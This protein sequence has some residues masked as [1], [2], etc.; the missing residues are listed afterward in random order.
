MMWPK[1]TNGFSVIEIFIVF[2][3]L[4]VIF[5]LVVDEFAPK[6]K[7]PLPAKVNPVAFGPEIAAP[8]NSSD[9]NGQYHSVALFEKIRNLHGGELLEHHTGNMSLVLSCSI[10]GDCLI[11]DGFNDD[12]G[13]D[14]QSIYGNR[15]WWMNNFF[16]VIRPDDPDY[17]EA[18]RNFL[19]Q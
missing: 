10:A 6:P 7:P 2:I 5:V 13:R 17:P 16:R 8:L 12:E 14:R 9:G 1:R 18:I 3:V 15:D 4:V 11:A 19:L